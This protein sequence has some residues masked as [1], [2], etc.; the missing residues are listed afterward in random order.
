MT[1]LK[2]YKITQVKQVK[3]RLSTMRRPKK[4]IVGIEE[5]EIPNL[6]G[7]KISSTKL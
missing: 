2:K 4:T 1:P 7:Q 6:K 3:H 5:S